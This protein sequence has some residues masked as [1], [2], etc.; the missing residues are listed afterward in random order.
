[1]QAQKILQHQVASS[2][3]FKSDIFAELYIT[4][5]WDVWQISTFGV[6]YVKYILPDA[7]LK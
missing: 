7:P 2:K 1:M 4:C 5:H 6:Q 3:Y